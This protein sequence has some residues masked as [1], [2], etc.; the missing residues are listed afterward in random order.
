[1]K[2]INQKILKLLNFFKIIFQDNFFLK[3]WILFL[4]FFIILFLFSN[5]I[6]KT[7]DIEYRSYI[8]KN[9]IAWFSSWE[10]VK[11]KDDSENQ[12]EKYEN[13]VFE[14]KQKVKQKELKLQSATNI[15]YL[16][17]PIEL[18]AELLSN[19]WV[20]NISQIVFSKFFEEKKLNFDVEFNK[21]KID[22]RWKYKDN[23]IKLYWVLD[24]SDEEML[25]VF[26]HEL[27][28]YFDINFL[29]KKVLFDLSDNFYDVSWQ[30]VNVLKEW[31]NIWDFVSGYAMT[32]KYEDFAESFTYF[33][34]FNDDFR[35][36]IN[37]SKK[38][39]QK[40]EFFEK[41]IFRNNEFKKTNFRI[42]DKIQDY[43]WD[44]T[45]IKFSLQNFLEYLKNL[46]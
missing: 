14:L 34:L 33:V 12:K 43:Y 36:K 44:I 45:K 27:W 13:I 3:T 19:T 37:N 25:S 11:I 16:Y 39:K 22:V 30:S 6:K 29:E 23:I 4:V 2:L 41:Y 40:Y 38:L 20:T 26:I 5:F 17:N 31:S 21:N 42:D 46:V 18:E 15:N 7:P 35:E 32:N 24:L 8:E 28:H 1:M 10:I 9:D